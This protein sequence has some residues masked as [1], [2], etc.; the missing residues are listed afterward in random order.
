MRRLLAL[1]ALLSLAAPEAAAQGTVQTQILGVPPSLSSPYL[2]ELV[3]DVEIGRYPL[4]ILYSAPTAEPL[5]VRLRLAITVDGRPLADAESAPF[6]VRPGATTLPLAGPDVRFD[7]PLE[8]LLATASGADGETIRQ[9]GAL[10]EGLYQLTAEAVPTDPAQ[11][12]TSVPGTAIFTVRYAEPPVP[13]TPPEQTTVLQDAPVFAWTAVSA[14]PGADVTYEFRLV[15]VRRLQTPLDAL[16]ANRPWAQVTLGGSSLTYLANTPPPTSFPAA[17]DVLPQALRPGQL[18]AWQVVARDE[19][20][21]TAFT[22]GGASEVRTF[23]YD[24]SASGGQV[25]DLDFLDLEPGFARLTGL[26][27]AILRQ[28]LTLDVDEFGARLDGAVTLELQLP[29]GAVTQTVQVNDLEIQRVGNELPVLVSGGLSAR[30]SQGLLAGL[31]DGLDEVLRLRAVEWTVGGGFTLTDPQLVIAGQTIRSAGTVRL[32]RNGVAGTLVAED[33]SGLVKLGE[34][35]VSLVVT[36]VQAAFPS[37]E[38]LA[39]GRL[40]LFNGPECD[41]GRLA[42]AGPELTA[43]VSCEVN[44]TLA[45]TGEASGGLASLALTVGGVRGTLTGNLA[46]GD[47][48]PALRADLT[49][50]LDAPQAAC[51]A[52]ATVDISASG[53]TARELRPSCNAGTLDLGIARLDLAGLDLSGLAYTAASAAATPEDA[54]WKLASLDLDGALSFPALGVSLPQMN[55][56]ISARGLEVPAITASGVS[57]GARP[58]RLGGFGLDLTEL[59]LPDLTIPLPSLGGIRASADSLAQEA[60]STA[61]AWRFALRSKLKM[62]DTPAMPACLRGREVDLGSAGYADGV[63]TLPLAGTAFNGCRLE[64]A[65]GTAVVIESLGGELTAGVSLQSLDVRDGALDLAAQLELG[66]PFSCAGPATAGADLDLSILQDGSI[67]GVAELPA[68]ACPFPLGPMDG[69]VTRATLTFD[70]ASGGG[71]QAYLASD[72]EIALSDTD[73][74]V[75]FAGF[76]LDAARI[77]TLSATIAGPFQWAVPSPEA[78]ALTFEIQGATLG[79]GGIAMD[80]RQKL[81]FSDGSE[82]G[83]TFDAVRVPFDRLGLDGRILFDAPFALQAG[84]DSF[85]EPAFRAV[86][87]TAR[88]DLAPGALLSLGQGVEISAGQIRTSG[89]ARAAV[90]AG[91]ID[92]EAIVDFQDFGLD[93]F[94]FGVARGE[95]GFSTASGVRVAV[96]DASGF[97]LDPAFAEGLLPD[98][99]GLPT[100]DVAYVVLRDPQGNALVDVQELGSGGIAVSTRGPLALAVPALS[101]ATGQAPS[102]AVQFTDL[103]LD[104]SGQVSAGEVRAALSPTLSLEPYGVPFEVR[105]LV[106][107]EQDVAGVPTWG[108]HLAGDPIAFEQ[109]LG[110]AGTASLLLSSNRIRGGLALRDLGA[111]VTLAGDASGASATL[112]VDRL[113]ALI[114]VPLALGPKPGLAL[115][116]GA[117]FALRDVNADE[118]AGVGL[119]AVAR[120]ASFQVT[121]LTP[122]ASIDGRRLDAGP[123]ALRVDSLKTLSLT[124]R[125]GQAPAFEV[126]LDLTLLLDVEGPDGATQK[127]SVPLQSATVTNSGFRLPRQMLS[128]SG[129]PALS[130]PPVAFGP[131]S[132]EIVTLDITRDLTLPWALSVPDLTA[133]RA[134]LLL[135]L[136]ELAD[137][138]PALGDDTILLNGVGYD[139]GVWVGAM[140]PYTFDDAA[141]VTLNPTSGA[142]FAFQTASGRLYRDGNAQGI[143]LTLTGELDPPDLFAPEAACVPADVTLTLNAAGDF[144]G[145]A[146][147]FVPCGSLAFG[148]ATVAFAATDAAAPAV[149]SSL[150]ITVSPAASSAV[151]DGILVGTWARENDPDLRAVGRGTVNLLTGELDNGFIDF[152]G[153][154]ALGVPF[155]SPDPLFAFTVDGLRLT[156]DRVQVTGGGTIDLPGDASSASVSFTDFAIGFSGDVVGG[157]A[158]IQAA[159]ALDLQLDATLD[160]TVVSPLAPVPVGAAARLAASGQVTITPQGVGFNA[161]G[162]GFIAYNGETYGNLDL[163]FRQF[164]IGLDPVRVASGVVDFEDGGNR[165]AYLDASGFH[166]DFIGAALALIPERIALPTEDV[167]YLDIGPDAEGQSRL[168]V[169]RDGNGTTVATAPNQTV[170]LVLPALGATVVQAAFSVTLDDLG[171]VGNASLSLTGATDL[172]GPTGLPVTLTALSFAN[173]QLSASLTADLPDALT[174][175]D[176]ALSASVS[177]SGLDNIAGA[178]GQFAAAYDASQEA[179]TPIYEESFGPVRVALRGAE[180][181]SGASGRVLRLSGQ[182]YSSLYADENGDEQPIHVVLAYESGAWGGEID[183]GNLP[184][185]G[186]DM[187][188]A[189]FEPIPDANDPQKVW[190]FTLND[191]E[192]SLSVAGLFKTDLLGDGFALTVRDLTL[193]TRAPYV[194]VAAQGDLPPQ[195]LDLFGGVLAL[196]A[197]DI[198]A[199]VDVNGASVLMAVEL[200]GSAVLL[201]K[202]LTVDGLRVR[203]DGDVSLAS[204]EAVLFRDIAVI[205]DA[206]VVDEVSIVAG[207]N[208]ASGLALKLAATATLPAPVASSASMTARIDRTGRPTITGPTFDFANNPNTEFAIP[209]DFGTLKLTA[210]ALDLNIAQPAQSAL[211]ATGVLYVENDRSD[212]TKHIYFGQAADILTDYGVRLTASGE[213]AWRVSSSSVS[214]SNPLEFEYDFFRFALTAL[215][216][217]TNVQRPNGGN[218]PFRLTLGGRAGFALDAVEGSAGFEDFIVSTEGVENIGRFA[219]GATFTLSEIFSLTVGEFTYAE[220]ETLQMERRASGARGSAETEMVDVAVRQYLRFGDGAANPALRISFTDAFVGGI[221]EVLFYEE[222][223]GAFEIALT[224]VEMA[225]SDAASLKASMRYRQVPNEGFLFEVAGGGTFGQTGFGAAGKISTL[226]DELRFG[227]FAAATVPIPIIPVI[228]ELDGIGGGF[229]YRPEIDDF[230]LVETALAGATA[231]GRPFRLVGP[232]PE[233]SDL[234]F[235]AFLYAGASVIKEPSMGTAMLKGHV[236]L[237]VTDQFTKLDVNTTMYG[238]SNPGTNLLAADMYLTV[239]Y[240]SGA[241]GVEGGVAFYAEFGPALDAEAGLDFFAL[242]QGS[243]PAVWGIDGYLEADVLSFLEA[244]GDFMAGPDGMLLDLTVEV[245][246]DLAIVSAEAGMDLL[247]WNLPNGTNPFGAY[248]GLYIGFDVLGG[249]AALRADAKGLFLKRSDA[250]Y[251]VYLAGSATVTVAFVFDGTIAGWVK[252][253]SRGDVDWGTGRNADLDAAIQQAR[254]DAS[255]AQT[256]AQE[257]QSEM[258]AAKDA[259]AAAQAALAAELANPANYRVSASDIRLAGTHMLLANKGPWDV[260]ASAARGPVLDAVIADERALFGTAAFSDPGTY[261]G[262]LYT[263][264]MRGSTADQQS[265]YYGQRSA[266]TPFAGNAHSESQPAVRASQADADAVAQKI[267]AVSAEADQVAQ[268]LAAARTVLGSLATQLRD[269]TTSGDPAA[270]NVPNPVS[271]IRPA[272]VGAGGQVLQSPGFTYD[273]AAYDAGADALDGFDADL[274]ALDQAYR[275]ALGAAAASAKLV[276][277]VL[278][279][280]SAVNWGAGLPDISAVETT[281]TAVNAVG[282]G[283]VNASLDLDGYYAYAVQRLWDLREWAS[284][285]E[286]LLPSLPLASGGAMRTAVRNAAHWRDAWMNNGLSATEAQEIGEAGAERLRAIWKFNGNVSEGTSRAN[287]FIASVN[288]LRQSP[289]N[290]TLRNSV[291]ATF[292]QAADQFWLEMPKR[293]LAEVVTASESAVQRLVTAYDAQRPALTTA[294]AT[295]TSTIDEMYGLKAGMLVSTYG[296]IE[297]YEA[298]RTDA[299]LPAASGVRNARADVVDALAPPDIAYLRLEG[300]TDDAGLRMA[301]VIWGVGHPVGVPELSYAFRVNGPSLASV[302]D[303]VPYLTSGTASPG[304]GWFPD[305]NIAIQEFPMLRRSRTQTAARTTLYVRARSAGGVTATRYVQATVPL[306]EGGTSTQGQGGSVDGTDATPPAVPTAVLPNTRRAGTTWAPDSSRLD[307]VLSSRD[308]ESGIAQWE[309]AL[310]TTRGGTDVRNWEVFQGDRSTS[311]QATGWGGWGAGDAIAGT[312][313]GL[314]LGSTPVYLSVRATNGAGAVSSVYTRYEGI[315]HDATPPEVTLSVAPEAPVVI[316]PAGPAV[317][318]PAVR[319]RAEWDAQRIEFDTSDIDAETVDVTWDGSDPESGISHY[320]LG[321]VAASGVARFDSTNQ[322]W[323]W[324]QQSRF[325][326][327]TAAFPFP[328]TGSFRIIARAQ[329]QAGGLSAPVVTEPI[330]RADPTRPTTPTVRVWPALGGPVLTLSRVSRDN[331]SGILGYQVAVGS[332]PGL[333]DLRAWPRDSLRVDWTVPEDV[334]LRPAAQHLTWRYARDG[335]QWVSV[336]AINGQGVASRATTSLVVHD[337]T[338]PVVSEASVSFERD[339]AGRITAQVRATPPQDPETGVVSA[340]VKVRVPRFGGRSLVGATTVIEV[341]LA[342]NGQASAGLTATE[343]ARLPAPGSDIA[344]TIE[345]RNGVGRT[346]SRT[347]WV[348]YQPPEALLD[349][350]GACVIDA[351]ASGVSAREA[352]QQCVE[353]AGM[354]RPDADGLRRMIQEEE[355]RRRGGGASAA[356]TRCLDN[357]LELDPA[358]AVRSCREN[359][360][361]PRLSDPDLKA[362]VAAEEQR[363]AAR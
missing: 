312:L 66:A 283:F 335:E 245:S 226:N 194:T 109:T 74:A 220:N 301:S 97:R 195:A 298:W 294:H 38:T 269:A 3:R 163:D 166:A 98:T 29:S 160:W 342:P 208:V 244:D 165:I 257:A 177:A 263:N 310:G 292:N 277:L 52:L 4:Q 126:A 279:G 271:A 65:P 300:D 273:V 276:D 228:I 30:V 196:T 344:I 127:V 139:G 189:T 225:M 105:E 240:G 134:D 13:I 361:L 156:Q 23:L 121:S 205:P 10:P 251:E 307:L 198:G 268:R 187:D 99:L 92:A 125:Q 238:Q 334:A 87:D 362:A 155:G 341:P 11:F 207:Q 350:Y 24:P 32:T 106:Y 147:P 293:G 353:R 68:L 61:R 48:S 299:G 57:L 118:L 216:I 236:L 203:S 143:E 73:N 213:T 330:R 229:F 22:E 162:T 284:T 211:L 27:D 302:Y 114:D 47:I 223:N 76:D 289:N 2:S 193:T 291:R 85:S 64:I 322:G 352:V 242:K 41:L 176:F 89:Q 218:L 8:T 149:T 296:M 100:Q 232:T 122:R 325:N 90:Q 49:A 9:T 259:L 173:G 192:L 70:R 262:W 326:S 249:L 214:T 305:A 217:E 339:R 113:D 46:S 250:L 6:E 154:L 267:Q 175:A 136:D 256:K 120:G 215:Q 159:A 151:Y 336:R 145:V 234:K 117:D 133:L 144:N 338:A 26:R 20:R 108:L 248:A 332:A 169:T 82:I 233:V 222:T 142:A 230:R 337:P 146:S 43:Q 227:I 285:R 94:P 84:L 272:V 363:R 12:V 170:D 320:D 130:V 188:F 258:A 152:A 184:A 110:D 168:V 186:L 201:D 316:P 115:T 308:P 104:A 40:Q 343:A 59:T 237:T 150:A 53:A 25:A 107:G 360:G 91:P 179:V 60:D 77:D 319:A 358:D 297:Q 17:G 346:S 204:G 224:D 309:V 314:N 351:E 328:F 345:A 93:L 354:P 137:A 174:G 83:A 116:L 180:V 88:L 281:G 274:A 72:I 171:N 317:Q 35:P 199:S 323:G 252:G 31:G 255:G 54:G 221:A 157:S 69:R 340:T 253:D 119:E 246:G 128:A 81:L 304:D 14:A 355:E 202:T 164:Q 347:A 241:S 131:L 321:W 5:E 306:A 15:E 295:F 261:E 86:P 219:G 348:A 103:A 101:A 50:A 45:L 19:N 172:S 148:P 331:E 290:T 270:F 16:L 287:D 318:R 71:T 275:D 56:G 75:G 260:P 200:D 161:G 178:L 95:A 278:D 112:T 303:D 266:S 1:F 141:S 28:R 79:L 280:A 181:A 239:L 333:D 182:V 123:L 34:D 313:Y 33:A 254:A 288:N 247:V 324:N 51:S 315:T 185:E 349:A 210:A 111:D 209:G 124:P 37:G 329:N 135:R 359:L 212:P 191:Q 42:L 286:A 96:L 44:E 39:D 327:R 206:F 167:G 231:N 243:G 67:A 140:E 282:Y 138:A 18:Y 102:V 21:L 264:V 63:L 190:D 153:P 265:G 129:Q 235:A 62:P 78:A 356:L 80:E 58:V 357:S 311:T 183:A 7:T 197:T 158:T 132:L 55:L 36:R